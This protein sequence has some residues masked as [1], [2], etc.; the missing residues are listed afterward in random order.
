MIC[1]PSCIRQVEESQQYR[2]AVCAKVVCNECAHLHLRDSHR[3]RLGIQF[4]PLSM[5]TV[6]AIGRNA[7]DS[8]V[9]G[10]DIAFPEAP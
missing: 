10:E 2:C 1:C 7:H 8:P 9:V 6:T 5:T 3:G 4:F